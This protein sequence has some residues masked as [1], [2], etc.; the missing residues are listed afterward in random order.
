MPQPETISQES[1]V[2]LASAGSVRTLKAVQSANGQWALVASVG[3]S[4]RTLRSQREAV[5]LWRS[6]DALYKYAR[7]TVGINRVEIIGQ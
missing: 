3:M 7:Q 4:E 1:L 5:R 6:L 2:D